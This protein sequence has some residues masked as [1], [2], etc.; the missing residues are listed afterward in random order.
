MLSAAAKAYEAILPS[1]VRELSSSAPVQVYLTMPS[2][3]A[4]SLTSHSS[5]VTTWGSTQLAHWQ[6]WRDACPD[7]EVTLCARERVSVTVPEH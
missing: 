1:V 2:L 4:Q 6:M 5:L 3:D 7:A